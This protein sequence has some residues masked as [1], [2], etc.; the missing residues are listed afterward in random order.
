MNVSLAI[1]KVAN[2]VAELCNSPYGAVA[3]AAKALLKILKTRLRMSA[4][5]AQQF[6][7]LQQQQ[8]N[9]IAASTAKQ[10]APAPAPLNAYGMN[11]AKAYD[12]LKQSLC[13]I[14]YIR[15]NDSPTEKAGSL[16][17]RL[18]TRYIPVIY[19]D[20]SPKVEAINDDYCRYYDISADGIK[21]SGWRSCAIENLVC[22]VPLN[23][24]TKMLLEGYAKKDSA[25]FGVYL[26]TVAAK[27]KTLAPIAAQLADTLS[28]VHYETCRAVAV[29]LAAI[30]QSLEPQVHYFANSP[31]AC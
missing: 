19:G 24:A 8:A 15:K 21:Q 1:I 5:L 17:L 9:A 4:N 22:C 26:A 13:V 30:M 25:D 2:Q 23:K 3:K 27:V 10:V 28:G 14:G 7:D 12:L 18:A 16:T 31:A 11:R 6:A 29:N 20:N